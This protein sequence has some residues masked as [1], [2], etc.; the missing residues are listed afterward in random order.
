MGRAAFTP[1]RLGAPRAPP[2][3]E[4]ARVQQRFD[5]ALQEGL[6]G[7]QEAALPLDARQD[8]AKRHGMQWRKA[9][10]V[11]GLVGTGIV[12]SSV[13]LTATAGELAMRLCASGAALLDHRQA[14]CSL[15][16]Q[17]GQMLRTGRDETGPP[18][19]RP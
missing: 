14:V 13:D 11:R 7:V 12:Q 5:V 15:L 6:E 4:R 10:M 16:R 9:R 1:A 2:G 17:G 8:T 3:H 19:L 18:R